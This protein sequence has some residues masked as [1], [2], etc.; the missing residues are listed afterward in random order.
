[1][2]WF[3]I[4]KTILPAGL[5]EEVTQNPPLFPVTF[6]FGV[7]PFLAHVFP[8]TGIKETPDSSWK[9]N[10]ACHLR[11]CFSIFGHSS[12]SHFLTAIGFFSKASFSGFCG[13]RFHLR[14][15]PHRFEIEMLLSNSFLIIV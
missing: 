10:I 13:V 4:L 12:L 9:Y 8:R 11:R 5:I 2:V 15:F 14:R 1:M 3:S 7:F 6:I